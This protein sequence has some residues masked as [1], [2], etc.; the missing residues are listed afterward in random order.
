[1]TNCDSDDDE[2]LMTPT[3]PEDYLLVSSFSNAAV[4]LHAYGSNM[5]D[6]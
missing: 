6:Q 3:N 4:K 2:S 5:V 1:M